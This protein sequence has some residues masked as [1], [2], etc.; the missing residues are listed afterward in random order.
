MQHLK[1][2][3]AT[4]AGQILEIAKAAHRQKVEAALASLKEA[5]VRLKRDTGPLKYLVNYRVEQNDQSAKGPRQERYDHL[6]ALIKE[7]AGKDSHLST[8]AW[9][10]ESHQSRSQLLDHLKA[11]LDVTCDYLS[12]TQVGPTSTFG[13]AKLKS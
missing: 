10:V 4:R 9:L 11:P 8:S 3:S 6:L 5:E 13:S 7:L 1:P 2:V 12:V